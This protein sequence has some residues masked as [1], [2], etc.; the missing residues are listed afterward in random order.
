M[1]HLTRSAYNWKISLY[2]IRKLLPFLARTFLIN[3]ALCFNP[4]SSCS[5][6]RIWKAR[7][8]H[9]VSKVVYGSYTCNKWGNAATW[10][11]SGGSWFPFYLHMQEEGWRRRSSTTL[12]P[13]NGGCFVVM[14][15]DG[16][17]AKTMQNCA[18]VFCLL[19]PHVDQPIYCCILYV[20]YD[21]SQLIGS[22]RNC[23]INS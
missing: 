9:L 22:S 2:I 3:C 5:K 1:P 14:S 11:C 21:L 4:L 19:D 7:K 13:I 6:T 23:S 20:S 8:L 18:R 10:L 16:M 17:E 15:V 12:I